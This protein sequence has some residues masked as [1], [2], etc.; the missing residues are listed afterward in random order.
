MKISEYMS[1]AS[2]FPLMGCEYITQELGE[3][4]DRLFKLRYESKTCGNLINEYVEND[5]VSVTYQEVIARSVYLLNRA[6]WDDLFKFAAE[7]IDPWIDGSS[8][9]ETTYGRKIDETLGGA[10]S[11]SRLN[12]ISGFDS[13][14]F[15]DDKQE[16]NE[17]KY[18]RTSSVENSGKNTMVTTR[19]S[20]QA[21]KLMGVT[22][23]FWDRYGI[24]RTVLADAAR[25][26]SLPLYELD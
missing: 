4:L 6:K 12:E 13:V 25:A 10:D 3:E 5:T 1:F 18:G 2:L 17:T 26:L 9:T 23:E 21:E 20:Q 22:M 8:T 16:S 7:D 19:R 15:V 14:D 24:T 11:Y